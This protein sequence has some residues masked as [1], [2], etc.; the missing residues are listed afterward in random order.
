MF[1]V[2]FLGTSAS[3]P[4]IYR[5]LSAHMVLHRQ[6]R[7]LIDCGEGT[8]RQILRSGLGF[9][10]LNTILLT[11]SHLDHILGLGGL[12]STLGRWET[13]GQIDIYAG[14]PALDRVADLLYHV[15]W[16]HARPP[17]NINLI[18]LHPGMIIVEDEKFQL[19]AFPVTHRGSGCYGFLFAEKPRRPFLAEKAVALDVPFGPERGKLVQGESITLADGREIRPDDVLGEAIP[20]TKYVHIG[21]V[22]RTQ[23]LREICHGADAITI[24]ATYLDEDADLAARFGH[25]TAGEAAR[26]ARDVQAKSLLLT[27]ISRRYYEQMVRQEAQFIF[28]ESY[29]A[30]DYDHFQITRGGVTRLRNRRHR[31]PAHGEKEESEFDPVNDLPLAGDA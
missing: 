5:G 9:R 15:V 14:Q 30:R 3:T 26:L 8:Q 19:S 21:D 4:S 6:Y 25:L 31:S 7:F 17:V 10:Q 2:I 1:D 28:P 22:G 16:R 27:H 20:G 12:I 29:V 23:N 18:P 24:E 13:L 11:H